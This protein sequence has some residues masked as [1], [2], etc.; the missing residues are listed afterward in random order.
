MSAI[1]VCGGGLVGIATTLMLA[2]D[3]HQVTVLE[4][5]PAPAPSDPSRAWTD[6]PRAG[7][8][9]F[10]QPHIL[11]PGF[12]E[13]LR[14]ELP[15]LLTRLNQAGC[16]SYSMI[17]PFPPGVTNGSPRPGDERFQ[18]VTGRRPV[19]EAVFALAA[20]TE[21]GVTV[22][23]GV[24]VAGLLDGEPVRPGTAHVTGVRTDAGERI[25][26]DLV[27][28]A[29]GRRTAS[30]DWLVAIGARKP[31]V[32]VEDHGYVYYSRFFTGDVAPVMKA[33]GVS[34][35]GSFSLLTIPSDHRTWSITIYGASRDSALKAV[36]D[37]ER[38]DRLVGACPLHRQWLDG[39]PLTGVLP[40]AGTSDICRR[41]TIDEDPVVTGFAAV[42]DAWSCTNPSA[43]RGVTIGVIHAAALRA[44]VRDHLA[45]PVAFQLG[46][47]DITE[48]RVAPLYRS[49]LAI[50]RA[51]A[52][53]ISALQ[54]GDEPPAPDPLR[55]RLIR[56]AGHDAH[57][58]RAM[59][60]LIGCLALPD[61]LFA[62][63]GLIESLDEFGPLRALPGPNRE[64]L[65]ELLAT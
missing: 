32:E 37:P 2:R 42:G 3:G 7:V 20:E 44:T 43:G 26:A 52:Q 31:E 30:V 17:R 56:T 36:R 35:L 1:V 11:L 61:D 60:E 33:P 15:D 46:W 38:F 24:R 9:Q 29:T 51:R 63:P 62:R 18:N 19:I 10:H 57:A 40:M 65:L 45:D 16:T 21:P 8:A 5:N 39:T 55:T 49:Q 54:N 25:P 47:D 50:D 23:R 58:F 12:R 48:R 34:P 14:R 41:F 28:D 53:E 6:W 22:R 64:Q 13:T 27:V 4:S 59:I